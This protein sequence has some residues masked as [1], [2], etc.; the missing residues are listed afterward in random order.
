MVKL[1]VIYQ[2]RAKDPVAFDGYYWSKHLPTVARWPRIRRITLAKG[3]PGEEIY[4]ICDLY[5]DSIDDLQG[6]LG[7]P[8]RKVSLE[9]VQHFPPFEGQVKRQVFELREFKL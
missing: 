4:Q 5:F 9:D 1:S 7:S 2:G 3:Q 8:E 6:A